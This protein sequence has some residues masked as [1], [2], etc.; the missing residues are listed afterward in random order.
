MTSL[1]H[2]RNED[3]RKQAH[4]SPVLKFSWKT[5]KWFGH[6]CQIAKTGRFWEKDRPK[7]AEKKMEGQH[8]GRHEEIPID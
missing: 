8:E 7:L 3:I 1:D 6:L 5:R 2:V 4:V